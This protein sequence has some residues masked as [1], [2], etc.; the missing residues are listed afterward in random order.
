MSIR[1][2]IENAIKFSRDTKNP[3][4]E[5]ATEQNDSD[6][7]III[8]D[9]GIGFDMTFHDKIFEIFQ[10][11]HRIEDFPGTG[12]GLALVVKSIKR[13]GGSV[14]AKSIPNQETS[15]FLK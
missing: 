9:N 1:N 7:T 4:I 2:V 5:I 12:I 6:I 15:F 3:V 8:K 10:R 14:W 13:M 11:L